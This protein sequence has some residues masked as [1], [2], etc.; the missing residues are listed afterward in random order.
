MFRADGVMVRERGAV[1]DEGLLDGAL[2]AQI[3]LHLASL[4]LHESK[5]EIEARAAV[6]GVADVA[7]GPGRDAAFCNRGANV[8]YG[9]LVEGE[10]VAPD[11]GGFAH[12]TRHL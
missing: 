10:E 7:A 6:I 2:D 11:G 9:R 1:V 8:F 3:L 4:L 5:C 12:V